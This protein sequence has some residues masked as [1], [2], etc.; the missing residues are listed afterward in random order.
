[1]PEVGKEN[2]F[3]YLFSIASARQFTINFD[4]ALILH[5]VHPFYLNSF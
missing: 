2:R 5:F 3:T 4:L 1:M